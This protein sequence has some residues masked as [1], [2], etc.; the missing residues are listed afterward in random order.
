MSE[1]FSK[2]FI[3]NSEVKESEE[4][5]DNILHK[6]KSLYEVIRIVDGKPLFLDKH[7]ERMD[8]SSRVSQLNLWLSKDEVKEKILQLIKI[9]K[10]RIG[11]IK[12]LFNFQQENINIF[13][14]YFVK[15]HYPNLQ[16]YENGVHT[17]LY[18]GERENPN[19]KII[20]ADFRTMVDKEI[21]IGN[22]FEAI[23]VDRNGY[24]TEGSKSNIFMIKEKNVL[25]APLKDVL[26]GVTRNVIMSLCKKNGMDVKEEKVSCDSLEN[27][28]ALFISG[29]SPKVLPIRSIDKIN[30]KSAE[31]EVV[32]K[33][34][35]AYDKALKDDISNFI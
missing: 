12:F 23:L 31:N 10:A 5:D 11:N 3:C 26:P 4:F 6:G 7:L 1:C 35:K 19:A 18:H 20:N 28:D 15:H 16:D 9:N 13:L 34:M 30:F 2:Y 22:A 21:V 32:L 24:I 27:L 33:I 25:T 29:T 8:N 17:I 14:C